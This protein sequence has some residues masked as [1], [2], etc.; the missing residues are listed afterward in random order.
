MNSVT[1]LKTVTKNVRSLVEGALEDG[2][3]L[4]RLAPCWVP[5][6]FL[7]PGKRLKL[8]PDDLYAFGLNRG[9]IDER[10]F[11]STTPAANENRTPDEGLSYVIVNR[12]RF[13]LQQAVVECG[14]D[15]I[16]KKIWNKYNRW[17][18]AA[19]SHGLSWSRICPNP[20]TATSISSSASS[21]GK[22]TWTSTSKKTITSSP[23]PLVTA[24]AKGTWTAGLCMVTSMASNPS[25]P[26]N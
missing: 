19:K 3:G 2:G 7:Q 4:L 15:L 23:S 22:P 11:S 20:N 18:K 5:R 25:P 10:W 16:G 9:G 26:K 6:S 14:A 21:I 12:Q 1:S 17:P 8:H 24:A 13:T